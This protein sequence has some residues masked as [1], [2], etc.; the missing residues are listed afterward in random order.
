[1]GGC[2]YATCRVHSCAK[3]ELRGSLDQRWGVGAG[4]GPQVR[5][6]TLPSTSGPAVYAWLLT[7]TVRVIVHIRGTTAD[8][9]L[10]AVNGMRDERLLAFQVSYSMIL[11]WLVL[12]ARYNEF[13]VAVS[14]WLRWHYRDPGKSPKAM[15]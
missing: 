2:V 9:M 11:P 5:M 15:F 7:V 10:R 14:G 3:H 4:A 6:I 12:L 1:M 13:D 8:A